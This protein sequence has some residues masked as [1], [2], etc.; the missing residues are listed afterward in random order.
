MARLS[1][2]LPT[3]DPGLGEK[4]SARTQRL[5]NRDG[6]FNVRRLG[7]TWVQGDWYHYWVSLSW[8]RFIA[9]VTG[10]FTFLNVCFAL[11]FLALG[12]EQSLLGAPTSTSE[13]ERFLHAFFFSVQTFNSVG[14]GVISPKGIPAGLLASFEALV[15]VL[16]FALI[17]G[18]LYARF[19]KPTARIL[20]SD[21]AI[22]TPPDP[23]TGLRKLML[24][25]A[26]ERTN[27]VIDMKARLIFSVMQPDFT[28]RYYALPLERDNVMFL[29]LNWTLVHDID[30]ESPL[31]ELTAEDLEQQNAEILILLRGFDDTYAQ[32]INARCSYR[33]DELRWNHRFVRPYR[34]TESG[35]TLLDLA[36]ISTTEQG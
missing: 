30:P 29:P 20:F 19:S 35:E 33:Y 5:V 25:I 17:T 9:A 21:A 16:T 15:G 12:Y 31:Y 22:I 23:K 28:R 6:S 1:S 18:L 27:T 2:P 11:G 4:F 14:Y 3:Q 24:R 7:P 26:N 8:P 13:L 32:D 36:L 10:W 34:T